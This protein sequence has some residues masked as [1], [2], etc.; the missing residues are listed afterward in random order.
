MPFLD[1]LNLKL[2]YERTGNGSPHAVTA[3]WPDQFYGV[4][5]KFL[6]G[7]ESS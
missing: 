2:Y 1:L 7:V 6:E 5:K 4:M 3:A